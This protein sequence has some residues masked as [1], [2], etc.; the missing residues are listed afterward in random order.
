MRLDDL[1][2]QITDQSLR[3][4]MEAALAEM[5]RRPRFRLVYEDHIPETTV[6]YGLPIQTGSLVQR[7]DDPQAKT[8]YRV[9]STAPHGQ[10][11]VEPSGGGEPEHIPVADLLAVKQSG[12]PIYPALTPL[13][14]IRRDGEDPKFGRIELIIVEGD[15]IKRLDLTDEQTRN[16]VRGVS[17]HEHLRQLYE[18]G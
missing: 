6:L 14:S 5:K 7:R 18:S 12:E 9:T 4:E 10:A 16:K 17:S 8:L 3:W 15:E 2:A 11:T 13:G 1:V